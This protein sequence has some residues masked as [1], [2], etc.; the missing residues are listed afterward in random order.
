MLV[1]TASAS[2]ASERLSRGFDSRIAEAFDVNSCTKPAVRQDDGISRSHTFDPSRSVSTTGRA[3][4]RSAVIC[5]TVRRN[6]SRLSL[7]FIGITILRLTEASP[8][9]LVCV[10]G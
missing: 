1:A 2:C 6:E 3:A 9:Q 5:A 8:D 7:T 4:T 10:L